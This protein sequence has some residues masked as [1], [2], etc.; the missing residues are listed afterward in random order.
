MFVILAILDTVSNTEGV[1]YQVFFGVLG[2]M[3]T[4]LVAAIIG[5]VN[6]NNTRFT[7]I[8]SRFNQLDDKLDI[9]IESHNRLSNNTTL[10][11][12]A[13]KQKLGVTT[14]EPL[15]EVESSQSTQSRED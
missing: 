7:G 2:V 14:P 6:M 8:D 4:V 15:D 3:L 10:N 1:T 11:F 12:F 5:V 13:I 9:L